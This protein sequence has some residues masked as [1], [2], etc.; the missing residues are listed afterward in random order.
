MLVMCVFYVDLKV[1]VIMMMYEFQAIL[2][3]AAFN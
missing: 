2:V 1:S 3:F